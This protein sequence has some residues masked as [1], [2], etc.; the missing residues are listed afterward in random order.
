M[1]DETRLGDESPAKQPKYDQEF[2][3]ELAAKGKGAWNEWRRDPANKDVRVTFAGVDFSKGPW[4]QINFEG[5]E[6]WE[7]ADF[8]QCRGRA[9]F[10]GASFGN[11]TCFDGAAFGDE[12]S[13]AGASF[14]TRVSFAGVAFGARVSFAGAAFGDNATFASATFGDNA[15][16]DGAAFGPG[17]FFAGAAFG[18]EASF[19]GAAFGEHANF[20]KANFGLAKFTGASFGDE[21]NFIGAEFD[22]FANFNGAVFGSGAHF[23]R[24][25]FR[26]PAGF[27]GQSREEWERDL[28]RVP[29]SQP[30]IEALREK[31]K[32][33][34]SGP[35]RFLTISFSRA[36]FDGV[37]VFSGRSFEK[38]ANFTNAR[39]YTPPD[40]EWCGGTT[41]IDFTGAYI[42]FARP[43]RLHW[44]R[45]S[46]VPL[47]L[48]AFRK[49]AEET[50]N[51]DLERDLY[52]EERKAERGVYWHQ[53]SGRDELEGKLKEIAEQKRHVW[54]EWRLKRRARNARWLGL[55]AKPSQL[56]RLITH[57]LWIL[58]MWF[59][60]L[61]ADYG[62][63]LVRPAIALG[64]SWYGSYRLY[65]WVLSPTMAQAPDIEKYKEAV[66]RLALG[67]AVPFV[68][69]LTVDAEIKKFLFCP[70]GNC[71]SPLMPPDGF[72]FL[73]IAQ[74][75][76]SIILVFFIG[77]ALRNYFRIK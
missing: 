75:L 10:A 60:W 46:E 37:A 25:I 62:R 9:S 33:S 12:A 35:D 52:I 4:D 29:V 36:R 45:D 6:F 16:F 2:S 59:Y 44:T 56:V 24:A 15:S 69:P 65:R 43:G 67:N 17:A 21:A 34:G 32:K 42:G 11:S 30:T 74:N 64:L 13:F 68:G 38:T 51:H 40:F 58:V 5:F 8:S 50:K 47:R 73:V 54:L 77:L 41:R 3:L 53:L 48:R 55:L 1:V 76:L 39:F 26:G 72:Q 31:H 63:S 23:D 20:A 19:A 14:G 57:C 66:W 61:F 70:L 27:T 18:N 28:P 49:I 22:S 7:G 71:P